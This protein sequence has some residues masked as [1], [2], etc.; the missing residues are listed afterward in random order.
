MRFAKLGY[1]AFREV[2]AASKSIP[3]PAVFRSSKRDY[4]ALYERFASGRPSDDYDLIHA[5]RFRETANAFGSYLEVAKS[6]LELGGHG[7]IGLFAE[8]TFGVRYSSYEKELREPYDLPSEAFDV[9]LCLEVIEHMKDRPSLETDQHD[10]SCWNYSG[11]LNLLSESY[12]ILKPG[13]VLLLTTPNA[14]SVDAIKCILAG[15]HPFM[16]DPHV[17]ELA[18]QQVKAFAEHVGFTLE[19]FGTFF[20]WET[21]DPK[22]RQRIS[23][24]IAKLGFDSSHRGNDAYFAFRR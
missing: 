10:I 1:N 3:L 22:L 17:R 2:I 19:K 5:L 7:R 15:D 9:V 16:F 18:P 13:G 14:T 4:A 6:V 21:C 12:R 23:K 24:M 20:A 8:E 11:A